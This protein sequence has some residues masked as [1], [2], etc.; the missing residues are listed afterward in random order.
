MRAVRWLLLSLTGLATPCVVFAHSGGLNANGGHI[1]HRTG[2]YH[3]HGGGGGGGL[4]NAPFSFLGVGHARV[5]AR[6]L[7]KYTLRNGPGA[8]SRFAFAVLSGLTN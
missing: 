4:G 1:D 8:T 6:L 7:R 3:T 5:L 2:T